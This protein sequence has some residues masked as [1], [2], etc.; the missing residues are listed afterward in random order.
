L[1]YLGNLGLFEACNARG[2]VAVLGCLARGA[3]VAL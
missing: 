1:I 3:S 2:K